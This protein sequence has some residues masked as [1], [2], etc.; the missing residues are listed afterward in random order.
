MLKDRNHKW[1]FLL[2]V[3]W[4]A[5]AIWGPELLAQYG[6]KARLNH[7]S[8]EVLE[9]GSEGYRYTLSNNEKLFILSQCLNH[10]VVPE[11]EQS[12]MTKVEL[13]EEY[14]DLTGSYAFVVNHK[15]PSGQEITKEE[16]FEICNQQ[17][18][19]L[20]EL[21]IFPD[22]VKEVTASGHSA[23]LYSAI[24]VL[25]P[26]NNLSAWKMSLSTSQQNADKTNQ[27]LDAY[28]DA[29]TGKIYEFYV[30]TQQEWEDI[31]ADDIARKW[32]DYMGLEGMEV[33]EDANPLLENTPYFKKYRFPG[34]DGQN[35]VVT[36]GFY[37]GIKELFLKISK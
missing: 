6:D 21:G 29:E 9:E 13:T 19:A 15:D 31:S 22:T 36:V 7:I 28:L 26:R 4:L 35:T 37:E 12:A 25:E 3:V 30:R 11:S 20:K 27:I 32:S 5:A 34:N 1:L 33:W 23:V 8:A 14:E 16:I 18:D 10:Q 24:D 17:V 2:A